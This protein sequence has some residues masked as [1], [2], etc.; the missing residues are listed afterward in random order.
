M[1]L[2]WKPDTRKVLKNSKD[3]RGRQLQR[4]RFQDEFSHLENIYTSGQEVSEGFAANL[5]PIPKNL[6]SRVVGPFRRSMNE[7]KRE[8]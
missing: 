4:E 1:C 8:L 7:E 3:M 6:Q 5:S 2:L